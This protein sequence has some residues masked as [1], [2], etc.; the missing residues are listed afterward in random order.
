MLHNATD[1]NFSNDSPV[2]CPVH[3]FVCSVSSCFPVRVS[4]SLRSSGLW[5]HTQTHAAAVHCSHDSIRLNTC[6][7]L[8][9]V[10][11]KEFFGEVNSSRTELPLVMLICQSSTP[12]KKTFLSP[13]A[14]SLRKPFD[15]QKTV[16]SV[17]LC[18]WCTV[19]DTATERHSRHSSA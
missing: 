8:A 5:R 10:V 1:N 4:F 9:E 18:S 6:R 17:D 2:N 12:P 16:V 13:T 11:V 15:L 19:L 7:I 3:F 14:Q